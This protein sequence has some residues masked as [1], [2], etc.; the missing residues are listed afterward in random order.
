MFVVKLPT[1]FFLL[2][3]PKCVCVSV[4]Q[5]F[6]VDPADATCANQTGITQSSYCGLRNPLRCP[7][8]SQIDNDIKRLPRHIGIVFKM[9]INLINHFPEMAEWLRRGI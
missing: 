1:M 4:S 7:K 2:G 8:C 3:L 9:R 6:R 5:F